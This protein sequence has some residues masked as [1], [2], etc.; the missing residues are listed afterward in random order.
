[1]FIYHISQAIEN[2]AHFKVQYQI[3]VALSMSGEKILVFASKPD[4]WLCKKNMT[5]LVSNISQSVLL[6]LNEFCRNK[7]DE[8][9]ECDLQLLQSTNM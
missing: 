7:P 5:N 3:T 2:G 6:R 1:M 9:F 4:G 8:V